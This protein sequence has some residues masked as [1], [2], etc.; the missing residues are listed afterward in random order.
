ME[1][2]EAAIAELK[3][4]I[5]SGDV[6]RMRE[7]GVVAKAKAKVYNSSVSAEKAR[8]ASWAAQ[9]DV[10]GDDSAIGDMVRADE[11]EMAALEEL[12]GASDAV[13]SHVD[14]SLKRMDSIDEA[15]FAALAEVDEATNPAGYSAAQANIEGQKKAVVAELQGDWSSGLE[16]RLEAAQKEAATA[17]KLSAK[18]RQ[19]SQDA[20]TK[21]RSA[22]A[23]SGGA[24]GA[25]G[26][27]QQG[28]LLRALAGLLGGD[29]EGA[30]GNAFLIQ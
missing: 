23:G 21:E 12:G 30:G 20:V 6:E 13:V 10:D 25:M 8:R 11:A 22:G 26:G 3:T 17:S 19:R 18:A 7:A 27:A 29:G 2:M 14:E 1:E 15:G 28:E 5:A 24:G 9:E 4:A 16:E